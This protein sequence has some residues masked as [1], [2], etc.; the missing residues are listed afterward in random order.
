MAAWTLRE[1]LTLAR[2]Q[3]T[4]MGLVMLYACRKGPVSSLIS[5]LVEKFHVTS[6]YQCAATRSTRTRLFHALTC[7]PILVRLR[8]QVFLLAPEGMVVTGKFR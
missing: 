8:A 1:V 4:S 7:T 2:W 3:I 5:S 6:K